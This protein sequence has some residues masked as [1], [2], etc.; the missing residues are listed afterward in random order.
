MLPLSSSA[1]FRVAAL[2]GGAAVLLGAFGAHALRET[3]A[4]DAAAGG[5]SRIVWETASHYHLAHA[6]ALA[7][8]AAVSPPVPAPA[9]PSCALFLA[10]T[11]IFSGSLYLLALTPSR[12]WLGALTPVGGLLL[13]G[14]W[15]A[16]AGQTPQ[17]H[18]ARRN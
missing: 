1:Y 18:G 8:A 12:R 7:L 13:V 16:L 11:A 5:R 14:A 10:G 15:L 6:L 17:L 4:A 3:F 2:S 9:P